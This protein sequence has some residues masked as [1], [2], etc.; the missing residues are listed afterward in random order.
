VLC[1]CAGGFALI[2]REQVELLFLDIRMPG[3]SGIEL[4]RNLKELPAVIFTTAYP[5]HAVESYELGAVDY[6]MKPITKERFGRAVSCF[7]NGR[8]PEPAVDSCILR[9]TTGS[10]VSHILICSIN[11]PLRLCRDLHPGRNLCHAHDHEIPGGAAAR[12]GPGTHK[13][14]VPCESPVYP[15]HLSTLIGRDWLHCPPGQDLPEVLLVLI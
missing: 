2:S 7:L 14:L 15:R 8:T 1:Q 13:S 5:D 11:S 9:T 12:A 4:I 3:L 10:Y 6:L